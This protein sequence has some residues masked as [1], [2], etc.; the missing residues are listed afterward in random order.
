[1]R[2]TSIL[3]QDID[4]GIGSNKSTRLT[5][6]HASILHLLVNLYSLGFTGPLY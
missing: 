5:N 1:M 3:R 2:K 6:R 4:T